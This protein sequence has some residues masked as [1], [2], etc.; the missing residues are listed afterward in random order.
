MDPGDNAWKSTSVLTK[1]FSAVVLHTR[2]SECECVSDSTPLNALYVQVPCNVAPKI[3]ADRDRTANN[4]NIAW[5]TGVFVFPRE[6]RVRR[7][8][9]G[10]GGS[11]A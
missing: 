4:C 1:G 2:A 6:R 10:W 8:L 11:G 9:I 3:E 7:V 5:S